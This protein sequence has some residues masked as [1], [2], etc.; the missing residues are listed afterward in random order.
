MTPPARVPTPR[1]DAN[2]RRAQTIPP[3]PQ[4]E[5]NK[6]PPTL[7]QLEAMY[8]RLM[9]QIQSQ[10]D[11]LAFVDKYK[12]KLADLTPHQKK[13]DDLEDEKNAILTDIVKLRKVH[14]PHQSNKALR[15]STPDSMPP[16]TFPAIRQ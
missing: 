16:P 6:T 14:F 11:W 10:E 15:V 2:L 12:N 8:D 4:M 13:L 1:P 5:E 9:R 3:F 7:A